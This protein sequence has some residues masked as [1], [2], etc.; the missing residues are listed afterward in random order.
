MLRTAK[1]VAKVVGDP[2]FWPLSQ[3]EFR[4]L[5][6]RHPSGHGRDVRAV[7]SAYRGWGW[8]KRLVAFQ[9]PEEFDALCEWAVATRPRV[10]IEIGTASGATLLLWA[11]VA[12]SRVVSVDLPGGI[13]GGGYAE[14]KGRLF[15]EFV[16]DRPSVQLDL[17][18]GSSQEAATRDRVAAMLGAARADVLFIDGDHR[19]EGVTRDFEL[20]RDLVAPGG[21]IVFHDI[22]DKIGDADSQV[23]HLWRQIV[24][25]YPGRTREIVHD[26]AQ[27]W[28]GIGLLRWD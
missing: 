11:R 2:L 27:G 3:R 13:H 9:V 1:H 19:L 6:A 10:V 21:T 26:P 14:E 16:R 4:R 20:W 7:T 15:R 23:S 18:R 12:S 17:V 25:D 22:I 5:H 24:R 8:Y 28:A